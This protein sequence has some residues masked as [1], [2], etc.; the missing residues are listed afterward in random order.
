MG[1]NQL[2]FYFQVLGPW[3]GVKILFDRPWIPGPQGG[4]TRSVSL[5]GYDAPR[6]AQTTSRTSRY[7]APRWA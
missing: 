7:Q 4:V 5:P 3:M 2:A 6:R 1:V